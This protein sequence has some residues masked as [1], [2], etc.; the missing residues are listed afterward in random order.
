MSDDQ[1]TL[2]QR[3]AD[4]SKPAAAEPQRTSSGA[5]PKSLAGATERMGKAL[6]KTTRSARWFTRVM[7][8]IA[9]APA[10]DYADAPS[11]VVPTA[12]PQ[13]AAPAAAPPPVA[14]AAYG[15]PPGF[16]A[17]ANNGGSANGGA[18]K[19]VATGPAGPRRAARRAAP[20]E[21]EEAEL[22]QDIK[23]ASKRQSARLARLLLRAIILLFVAFVAWAALFRIEEVTRGDGRVV[24]SSQTQVVANLEGGIVNAVLVREGDLVEKGQVLLRLDN[25]PA[26]AQYRDNRAKYLAL[27][28]QVARLTAELAGAEARFPEEL[29]REAP[30]VVREERALMDAR[31]RQLDAQLQILRDQRRQRQQELADLRGKSVKLGQQLKLTQEQLAILEPLAAE[32]LAP[33]VDVIRAQREL[34]GIETDLDSARAQ[35]P[36]AEAALAEAERKIDERGATFK[37]DTQKELNERR[38]MLEGA[39]ELQASDRDRLRR[40]ELQAPM[41]GTVKQIYV[42]TVGGVVKPGQDLIELVPVEDTLL[43]EVKIRPADVGFV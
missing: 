32:G 25:A 34:T 40:T 43:V 18:P 38:T 14:E 29:L 24:A 30:D 36:R 8:R 15:A 35:I 28:A 33:R 41:R 42:K 7:D 19:N 13:A 22:I 39:T 37:A 16:S 3:S 23:E 10:Y 9:G 20:T 27:T 12:S 4:A 31:R 1:T 21:W 17:I 2:I 6:D 5:I 11:P 26:Q